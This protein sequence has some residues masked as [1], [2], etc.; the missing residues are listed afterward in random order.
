MQ[1]II[2]FK[3]AAIALLVTS[4]AMSLADTRKLSLSE[5]IGIALERQPDLSSAKWQAIA[6]KQRLHQ[7]DAT[8]LPKLTAE[9][10]YSSQKT[11]PS[12][13]LDADTRQGDIVASYQLIDG[14]QRAAN[15]SQAKASFDASVYGWS[16][17]R[18]TTI[19]TVAQSFYS[20]LQKD[21]LV[22]VAQASLDRTTAT[23]DLVKAQIEQDVAAKKDIYQAEADVANAKVALLQAR[24]NAVLALT[25][26]KQAMGVSDAD[27]IELESV[28]QPDPT[29]AVPALSDLTKAALDARPDYL[30]SQRSADALKA[31][32]AASKATN[33]FSLSVT[34]SMTHLVTPSN[35]TNRVLGLTASI[36]LFDGGSGRA[37]IREADANLK[38]GQASRDATKLSITVEVEQAYRNLLNAQAS[39]PSAISAE[40]AA[41]I[42][43]DAALAS[44]KEGLSTVVDVVTAQASLVTAQT[45][46]VQAVYELY[47]AQAQLNKAIGK[48]DA[49]LSG[50]K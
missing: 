7:V 46:R 1:R 10:A 23:R 21:E 3:S 37:S 34:A 14:G 44:R 40:T 6:A 27:P 42:A 28:P 30:Q 41:Q 38:S 11:T 9:Y 20:A 50:G 33:Q 32:L 15:R 47:I 26:L 5:A 43:Y 35:D 19:Y 16:A 17:T 31:A 4:A 12:S 25:T 22:K 13:T 39:L 29:V 49:I 45:S 2:P 18:Q 36:P 24:N 48:A 8:F